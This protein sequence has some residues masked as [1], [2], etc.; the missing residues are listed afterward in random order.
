MTPFQVY[1]MGYYEAYRLWHIMDEI[2]AR[3]LQHL[4]YIFDYSNAND[5]YRN[6]VS[7]WLESRQPRNK[8]VRPSNIP[9]EVM[10]KFAEAF[11]N[12]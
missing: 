2:K 12:G 8:P 1:E 3:E 4:S 6:K 10:E 7:G 5:E 9:K 11:N